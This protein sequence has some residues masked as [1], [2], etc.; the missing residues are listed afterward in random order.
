MCSCFYMC[1]KELFI[2]LNPTSFLFICILEHN[3]DV[4]F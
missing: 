3:G 1:D 2:D 4:L